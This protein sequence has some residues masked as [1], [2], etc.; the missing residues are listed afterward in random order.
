M[1][2]PMGFGQGSGQAYV[3]GKN[4]TELGFENGVSYGLSIA[5]IGFIVAC[6]GGIFYF[7]HFIGKKGIDPDYLVE[8]DEDCYD[9]DGNLV[10]DKQLQKALELLNR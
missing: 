4:F 1:L 10:N 3:W 9:K 5:A 7:R 6:L 8:L 2:L